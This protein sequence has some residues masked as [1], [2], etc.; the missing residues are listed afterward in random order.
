MEAHG[1]SNSKYSRG[2]YSSERSK[3][4]AR[5]VPPV[6]T[7][8]VE[9]RNFG[10][11]NAFIL[12]VPYLYLAGDRSLLSRTSVAI[13]GSRKVS[14]EGARLAAALAKEL[15]RCGIVT[16]SG[17]AEGVDE[18]AHA[19][20][21]AAGGRTIAVIG[22]PLSRVY[23]AKHALLQQ[24]IYSDHLLISPFRDG[25]KT[26]PSH[27]PERNRVMAMLSRATVIIEASDTSGSLHQ[28][29]EC[30]KSGK[31]LFIAR[32]VLENSRLTWPGR[33]KSAIAFDNPI[34]VIADVS[35]TVDD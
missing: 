33:F 24:Q 31:R 18:A 25:E 21:I 9:S 32:S 16:M 2:T 29:V 20:A 30:E 19:A 27:F 7:E 10:I 26:F 8:R 6:S 5:Y 13:V 11:P 28:A 23:P 12:R 35:S 34:D 17:L 3:S 14:P 22:T 4:Q 15:A 1:V